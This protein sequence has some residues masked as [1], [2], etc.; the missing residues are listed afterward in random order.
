MKDIEVDTKHLDLDV[1]ADKKNLY[2]D[3]DLTFFT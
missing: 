1:E 3:F 2:L